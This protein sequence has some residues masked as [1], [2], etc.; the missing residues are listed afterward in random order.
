[1][2]FK[3]NSE[4]LTEILHLRNHGSR[5]FHNLYVDAELRK[6]VKGLGEILQGSAKYSEVDAPTEFAEY[7][8]Q[9]ERILQSGGGFFGLPRGA[10]YP[11]AV[12]SKYPH[13]KATERSRL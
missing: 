4:E 7:V 9:F 5:S 6:E 11:N 3:E 13:I 8:Q 10:E 2:R 1:V 12:Q